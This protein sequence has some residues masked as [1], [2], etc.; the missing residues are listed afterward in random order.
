MAACPGALDANV[1]AFLWTLW[2]LPVC[3]QGMWAYDLLLAQ[4]AQRN[5]ILSLD[6]QRRHSCA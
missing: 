1:S 3:R 5:P 2:V 4:P 6:P